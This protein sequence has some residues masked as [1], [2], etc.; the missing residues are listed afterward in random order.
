[1]EEKNQNQ[2][3]ETQE[4]KQPKKGIKRTIAL[5]V[6][7]IAFI[8]AGV[9]LYNEM[10]YEST[11]DAY[12]ETTTVNVSPKISGQIEEVFV[13]DN[14]FVHEGDLVAII[15]SADYKIKL[16]QADSNYEKIKLDQSNAKAN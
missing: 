7:V 15:D 11:D 3:Q 13:K 1:M 2:P 12:V 6:V 4:T 5:V 14:Q 10:Q 16:E 9:Y 8:L